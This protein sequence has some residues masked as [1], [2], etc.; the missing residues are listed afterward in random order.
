MKE[1]LSK[2][3]GS[4]RG[5][6]GG[7]P[8]WSMMGAAMTRATTKKK[9][10]TCAGLH[11][12][13]RAAYARATKGA[14]RTKAVEPANPSRTIINSIPKFWGQNYL[15]TELDGFCSGKQG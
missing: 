13:T 6:R 1:K 11:V 8:S 9:T 14:P 2:K 5:S 4:A 7:F 3:E 15:E 12:D 10:A